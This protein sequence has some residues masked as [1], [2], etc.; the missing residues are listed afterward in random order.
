MAVARAD[1]GQHGRIVE[2]IDAGQPVTM[3]THWQ[4]LFGNGHAVG[5]EVLIELVKHVNRHLADRIEWTTPSA[6]AKM[7]LAGEFDQQSQ[8]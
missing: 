6:I 2:L 8:M 3:V 5:L 4:S 1:D 7:A